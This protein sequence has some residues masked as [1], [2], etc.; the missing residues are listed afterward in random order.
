M[1]IVPQKITSGQ[2]AAL[3]RREQLDVLRLAT[4]R[5]KLRLLI[6][7]ADGVELLALLPPQDLFLMARELGPDQIPELLQMATPEQWTALFD[8][9]CWEGDRFDLRQA[10]SWLAVLLDGEEPHVVATLLELD[11]E[12]L[13][14]MLQR[15]VQVLSGP[16]EI[17]DEAERGEALRRDGGYVLD[18]RDEEGAKLYGLLLDILLRYVPD[19]FRYLLEAARAEGESLLEESVYRQRAGRLLDQ[20]IP[21]PQTARGVYAWLDP[22]GFVAGAERKVPLGG[23]ASGAA[24]GA[25]LQLARPG[26][27]LA[28]VL[29]DGLDAETSW[30]L[31]CLVNKVLMADGVDPGDL[32]AVRGAVERTFVTLNLALEHL[33]GGDAGEAGRCLRQ[34]YA[35]QLFHLGFS[36]TLRL[37]RRARAVRESAVGAYLDPT[38]GG[39]LA[40]LLQRRPQFAEAL[41]HPGRAGARAFAGVHELRLAEA[42]LDRLEVQQRLF[43]AHFTFALPAPAAWELEGCHPENGGELTLSTLFLTALANRLLGRPFAPVPLECGDLP[44]LHALVAYEGRLDP[45]LRE[46]TLAW[47]EGLEPGGAEFGAFCLDRWEEEFCRVGRAD[48]DPRY[49]GGL[50][51]R[52]G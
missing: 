40:A 14:L 23:S 48:L 12:L 51:V 24:P 2:F 30:E 32:E 31:V 33:A 19:F 17:F 49:V 8:F 11:F 44:D 47:L 20:G 3:T 25:V 28:A 41:A 34:T 6:D 7:A 29:A 15:E 43:A 27:L 26:G 52:T 22:E 37:Q 36:L 10:R 9:D 16:E 21:E 35:E 50:I 18:F 5:Q 4:A 45:A 42:W 46:K 39:I 38:F 1:P 13:V